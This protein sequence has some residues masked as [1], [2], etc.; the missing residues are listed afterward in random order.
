MI[1]L[2][3]QYALIIISQSSIMTKIL[4]I[5]QNLQNLKFIK[6]TNDKD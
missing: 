2:L 6:Q 3:P 4:I 1:V 5:L